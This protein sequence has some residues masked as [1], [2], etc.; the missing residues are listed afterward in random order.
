M[1][2]PYLHN[3]QLYSP[4]TDPIQLHANNCYFTSYQIYFSKISST[5]FSILRSHSVGRYNAELKHTEKD[6]KG[7]GCNPVQSNT[8]ACLDE[9]T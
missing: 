6:V 3:S 9:Q 8:L 2:I 1:R 4:Q 5:T 7:G